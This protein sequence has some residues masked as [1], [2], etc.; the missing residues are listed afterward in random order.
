MTVDVVDLREFYA[1]PL[2]RAARGS[3]ARSLSDLPR[4][5]KGDVLAGLGYPLP[6]MD[7]LEEKGA[8]ALVMMPARQ[9]ALLWPP[10][11]PSR[12]ALVDEHELPLAN[13]SVNCMVMLHMLENTA[14]PAHTLEEA[15]RVLAPEGMLIVIASNR[16]G[17]W[18]R[19]EHT[20]FGN[21]RPFSRRQLGDL[22]RGAKLTPVRWGEALHFP[23]VS[24]P[25]IVRLHR[26]IEGVARRLWPVFSGAITVAATKRLYQGIGSRERHRETAAVPVLVPQGARAASRAAGSS[27]GA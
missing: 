12:T 9:G 7:T 13:A 23:P 19:F 6:L 5:S 3:L 21:G 22:L 27:S 11:G 16:R 10:Q 20:P 24:N 2:G 17:L 1:T 26:A 25:R 14:D 15:C 18:T 4:A 8:R